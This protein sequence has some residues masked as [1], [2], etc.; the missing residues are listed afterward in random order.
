M[1]IIQATP[2]GDVFAHIHVEGRIHLLRKLYEYRPA[3]HINWGIGGDAVPG[4]F[5]YDTYLYG[6]LFA[7]AEL[8]AQT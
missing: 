5:P 8:V 2:L 4:I 7:A 3:L 6:V 1:V